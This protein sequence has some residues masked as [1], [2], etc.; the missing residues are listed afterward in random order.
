M[1][2]SIKASLH[3]KTNG[4]I[5]CYVMTKSIALKTGHP[6]WSKEPALTKW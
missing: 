5:D 3:T 4:Q 6:R 2:I 1:N